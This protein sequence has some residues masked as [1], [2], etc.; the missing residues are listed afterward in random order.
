MTKPLVNLIYQWFFCIVSAIDVNK[1]KYHD[2]GD[3]VD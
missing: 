3:I 2:A 1:N